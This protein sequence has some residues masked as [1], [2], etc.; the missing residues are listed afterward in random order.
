MNLYY[1]EH[2]YDDTTLDSGEKKCMISTFIE[3]QGIRFS[4]ILD[5]SKGG[6]FKLSYVKDDNLR[7]IPENTDNKYYL[8]KTIYNL[9]KDFDLPDPKEY[10]VIII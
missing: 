2:S 9:L 10:G 7:K 8:N 6:E 3:D 5:M 4:I 1:S